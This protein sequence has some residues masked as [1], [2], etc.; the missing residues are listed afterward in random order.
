MH[1]LSY[2]HKE[3]LEE[4]LRRVIYGIPE[5]RETTGGLCLRRGK[6]V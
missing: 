5:T 6:D 2:L 3:A 1:V 4:N